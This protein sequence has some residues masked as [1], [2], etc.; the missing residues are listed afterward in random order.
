MVCYDNKL[1]YA[2]YR[3]TLGLFNAVP[4]VDNWLLV[5]P[6][7][8]LKVASRRNFWPILDPLPH[9]FCEFSN[10][11]TFPSLKTVPTVVTT[12]GCVRSKVLTMTYPTPGQRHVCD[13]W[14]KICGGPKIIFFLS[15]CS[16]FAFFQQI[17]AKMQKMCKNWGEKLFSAH[18]RFWTM[19]HKDVVDPALERWWLVLSTARVVG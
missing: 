19:C 10:F 15:F 6:T 2:F 14:F 5:R 1:H 12:R 11:S 13:A 16:F 3:P 18:D 9:T 7:E 8:V 4:T 17:S